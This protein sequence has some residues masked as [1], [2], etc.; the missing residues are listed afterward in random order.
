MMSIEEFRELH[1]RMAKAKPKLFQLILPD[2]P[3]SEAKLREVE[4]SIGATLPGSYKQFLTEFG[5]GS[6]GLTNV[7]STDSSG[8]YYLPRK[9]EEA[10][11][12][13]PL[14]LIP[15]SDDRAGGLYVL[16]I[17][18]GEAKEPLFYWNLDGGL[19]ETEFANVLEFVARYAYDAA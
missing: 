17:E 9:Q 14:G 8:E 12:Y 13:L 16:K 6:F 2:P 1:A 3:A 5:G 15:V 7:C 11:G 18:A 4:N 19:Q 10:K